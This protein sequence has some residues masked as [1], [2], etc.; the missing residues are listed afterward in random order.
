MRFGSSVQLSGRNSRRPTITGTSREASV[1]ETSDGQLA[2]LPSAEAYWG[3]TPTELCPF[4]GN[5]VAVE[6]FYSAYINHVKGL[7]GIA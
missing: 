5:A 7:N 6:N 2:A 4:F 3:A 1:T